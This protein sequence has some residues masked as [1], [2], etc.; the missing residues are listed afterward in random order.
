MF[1]F[2]SH[3][4]YF[5]GKI[6][7]TLHL[8]TKFAWHFTFTTLAIKSWYFIRKSLKFSCSVL[9]CSFL[10]LNFTLRFAVFWFRLRLQLRFRCK[11]GKKENRNGPRRCIKTS[12]RKPKSHLA[13]SLRFYLRLRSFDVFEL[14]LD[15]RLGTIFRKWKSQT[16]KKTTKTTS[17]LDDET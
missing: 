1:I 12:N 6:Q 9:L 7:N 14:R 15:L 10:T 3:L 11:W 16:A 13:V 17:K 2:S 8:L 4:P 5:Y